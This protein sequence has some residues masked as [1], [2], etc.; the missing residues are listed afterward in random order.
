M[1]VLWI[2]VGFNTYE[3]QKKEW[4]MFNKLIDIIAESKSGYHYS[5]VA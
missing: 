1:N 3:M 5:L 4:K 2:V